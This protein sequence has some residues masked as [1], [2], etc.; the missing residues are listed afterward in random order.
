M[1]SRFARL[2]AFATAFLLPA[3]AIAQSTVSVNVT[4]NALTASGQAVIALNAVGNENTVSFT[5]TWDPAVL[6][7][8]S[9]SLGSAVP[10]DGTAQIT[11]NVTQVATGKLGVLIGL[12]S[13]TTYTAGTKQ[14]L[15]VNFTVA[16]NAASTNVDFTDS[17]TARRVI[18][19][20]ANRLDSAVFSGATVVANLPPAPPSIVTPP[21]TATITS[22]DNVS[23]SVAVAGNP[24]PSIKWQK[25][26]NPPGVW[27]DLS[28]G[29]RVSGAT[30]NQLTL[31]G[32]LAADAGSYRAVA[33]NTSGA[34]AASAAATL[35]VNKRSQSITFAE[36]AS[37][38]FVPDETFTLTATGGASGLPVTFSGDNA[39]VATVTSA[40]L[41]TVKGVG[42]VNIAA[43]QA[44]NADFDAASAVSR[45]LTITV[46]AGGVAISAGLN[47]TFDGSPKPVTITTIPAGLAVSVTYNGSATAPTNAGEYTVV[48]TLNPG[49][50]Y[51]GS[52]SGTLTIAKANQAINFPPIAQQEFSTGTLPLN[53]TGG[54]SG[55]PVTYASSNPGVATISG[56]TV[57][58]V[59]VGSTTITANQA[60]NANYNAATAVDQVLTIVPAIQTITFNALPA[61]TFDPANNT[62]TLS[63]SSSSSLTVTF[64][65]SNESIAT[66]SGTT[67][68]ILKAGT[69]D[70]I[71]EQAGN[72]NFGPAVAVPRTLVIN[73]ATAQLALTNLAATYD[74]TP[75]AAGATT[76]PTGLETVTF[77]YAPVGSTQAPV[78]TA[79]TAAGSY[80]VVA[81]L[82]NDNYAATQT[83]TLVIAKAPQTISFAPIGAKTFGD[84]A[85]PVVA[86]SSAGL[87]VTISLPPDHPVLSLAGS[88]A[89]GYTATILAGGQAGFVATAP[90][91]ANYLDAE[92]ANLVLTIAKASATVALTNL[93][94]TY[95]GSVKGAGATT[96]PATVTPPIGVS[97][98]YSDTASPTTAP[99]DA[100]SYAV[101]ATIIDPRFEGP[102]ATGTITINKAP[103]TISFTGFP[104]S[105]AAALDADP[106]SIVATA[107]STLP[108]TY[109][110]SNAAVATINPTTGA[111]TLV[112]TGTTTITASIGE[113]ANYL[114]AENATRDL[115]ISN[116]SQTIDFAALAPRT[117]AVGDT[118][119][120]SATARGKLGNPTNLLVLFTSSDTAVATV[121][122]PTLN[123]TTGVSSA[124]V[125]V[126]KAGTTNIVA[127]QGGSANFAAAGDVSRTLVINKAP[128]TIAF[129]AN[130][131]AQVYNG[132]ARPVSVTTTPANLNVVFAYGAGATASPDAPTN[133]G[134][135]PVT[136]LIVEDNYVG[137]VSGELVIAKADQTIDFAAVGTK[138]RSDP[139]FALAATASSLLTDI[140]FTSS[141]P[142]VAS[143]SG[144][145][146]TI[147]GLG[148]TTLTATQAGNAN[149]NASTATQAL[150]V[151]PD[152]P[153]IVSVPAGPARGLKGSA[154]TYGSFGVNPTAAPYTFAA[155]GLPAGL[156]INAAGN[157]VG[158]P[159]ATPGTFSVTVR[160][161]NVTLPS[162]TA[163]SSNSRTFT[164][165]I[166]PAVPAFTAPPAAASGT[167]GASYTAFTTNPAL[168]DGTTGVTFTATGLPAGLS[169]NAATG[170]I[171]GTPTQ[172]GTFTVQL[173]ATNA[174]GSTTVP[175]TITLTLPANAPV[176]S[177]PTNPSGKV[178]T[179]F[180]FTPNFGAA[181]TA[182]TT[183]APITTGL[184]PGVTFNATTGA[185]GGT[186]T[187]AGSFP[188]T[189]SATRVGITATAEL[190]IVI[191]PPDIAPSVVFP[192]PVAPATTT[193]PLVLRVGAAIPGTGIQ[194]SATPA[195]P[196]S[197]FA[198]TGLPA[199]LN[200]SAAG[201]LTGTP[202]AAGT[203]DVQ[204]TATT[205]GTVNVTG[206]A[207]TWRI[208]VQPALTAP[209]INSAAIVAGRVNDA[210]NFTLTAAPADP[211]PTFALVTTGITDSSISTAVPAGLNLAAN[212]AITGTPTAEGITKVLVVATANG[213][214]GPGQELTFNIAPAANVPVVNS[215]GS[216]TGTAGQT[217]TYQI[218]AT[219]GALTEYR[220]RVVAP[221]TALPGG[222]TFDTATGAIFGVP[223]AATPTPVV[224]E[225][226]A[227]NTNGWSLYKP[228]SISIVAPPAT[229]VIANANATIVGR[230]GVALPAYQIVASESPTAFAATGLPAGVVLAGSTGQ[231]TGTPTVSG[232]F[233]AQVSAANAASG[234]GA[235][236]PLNFVIAAAA[237]APVI[238]GVAPAAGRVGSDFSY[239]ITATPAATS[240][241]LTGTLPNGLA[242]NSSTGRIA[243]TPTQ[244]G[245]FTISVT[246][247]N[248]GGTSL[249]QTFVLNIQSSVSAPVITSAL[250]ATA[251]VGES[252][253]YTIAATNVATTRPL[254]PPETLDAVNLPPGLVANPAM[255]R[256][257][258]VPT[259]VGLFRA[260]LVGT[261]TSGAGPARDLFIE[262]LP[263]ATAPVVTSPTTAAGQVGVAFN[264][265]I[266]GTNTPTAYEVLGAPAWLTVSTATG[267]VTGVPTDPGLFLTSVIALNAAGAST[268]IPL[269]I[270]IAAATG[271][272]VITSSRSASGTVGVAFTSTVGFSNHYTILA[273][274][275]GPITYSAQGLP[276]GLSVNA[277]SGL[278]T[279][280]PAASGTFLVRLTATNA[281]GKSYPVTLT[282]TIAPSFQIN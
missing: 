138:L 12:E 49:Q 36:I 273:S 30:T 110:S 182:S 101:T 21:A 20:F 206:P 172:A 217:F 33:S 213:L 222:L 2:F 108:V 111:V 88:P 211:A 274:G 219:N 19:A 197:T 207:S 173:T 188:V 152:A 132:S 141:N 76:T 29:G 167:V 26:T 262:V 244:A 129:V 191:N 196:T 115:V 238:G 214:T 23:F 136:A 1:K 216:A 69:V 252:F 229:P 226:G 83:G 55:Q 248:D 256:I 144:A 237:Q 169:V 60:G 181:G 119:T 42:T 203:V 96:I 109:A 7:Y 212:G 276:S 235:S 18:D 250:N 241:A 41:V 228:V 91:N 140:T 170:A 151:N 61:R 17:P 84:P 66:V 245:L 81:T 249:P 254:V 224:V 139:A 124:T 131:L 58:F 160:V 105:N 102:P 67:L 77:T 164:F 161:N 14:L 90:G 94:H 153:V 253:T 53:A 86:T 59:S 158:T 112:G 82:N 149:Y 193:N 246:A 268:P 6:T 154:L 200:L 89:A 266:A 5:L 31:T 80:T 68:T 46:A 15:V 97:F 34:D 40:G 223:S 8:V 263:A 199:G 122:A 116:A 121:S 186:P 98:T 134:S 185:F 24:P 278:I 44:G 218:T 130:T 63:A 104:P 230:V 272:P 11:R 205:T 190:T 269:A 236:A 125:T 51:T 175:V 259:T 87:P 3:L 27:T 243:G 156:S 231:I 258:G 71:A 70:I 4:G 99:T 85:F 192:A 270:N 145:T 198:A 146:V 150:V 194:L 13:G 163:N 142:L 133:A 147:R 120:V 242:F 240:F 180:A 62:L 251:T 106:F 64:R 45:P 78:S 264:Y 126:L 189:V 157:I 162:P 234:F 166:D 208:S 75:K 247:T 135:Y 282:L 52:A 155:E 265:A 114:A 148:T 257:E 178:G 35:T 201:L 281:S 174:T 143:V 137:T 177:G 100:G 233:T 280:T 56:N 176:Y 117:Y 28:N 187:Q 165:T 9:N 92:P 25:S 16:S 113:S 10:T 232:S 204:V 73:K 48:A 215:N 50:N 227:R 39:A 79:P 127:S 74:G 195:T 202:T 159:T 267:A 123:E 93:T 279:G 54:A 271:A 22:G 107:T 225:V 168:V 171:T 260:S 103:Q 47:A 275:T 57:T 183:F 38:V 277:T 128:A 221:A 65:S 43:N 32:A 37:R 95:N 210:V 72:D 220:L 261:N 239:T 255:G 179:A 209:V 118:F 184:P